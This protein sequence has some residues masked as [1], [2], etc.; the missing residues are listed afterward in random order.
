VWSFG[1]P[2]SGIPF[3]WAASPGRP[4]VN[5]LE[6]LSDRNV[7]R[8]RESVAEIKRPGDTAVA[9]LHWGGNWGYEIPPE[10]VRFAHNL[11]DH[12]GIDLIHGHSS[13]H[14]KGLEIYRN[15]LI[16][17]GCGDFINDYEGI[18]G[19]EQFRADLG[20]MYLPTL[21]PATGELVR[22]KIIPTRIR[23][24]QVNRASREDA[25]PMRH[26]LDRESRAFGV[27]IGSNED[28]SLIAVRDRTA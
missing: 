18:R 24:L 20:L 3:E 12:A 14:V 19:Y 6:S 16:L 17:Y 11:I 10:Q 13:H 8:V 25:L 7:L 21:D 9:S 26:V 5:F 15:K 4:G 2:N 23:N 28:N 27:R 1:F 22:L